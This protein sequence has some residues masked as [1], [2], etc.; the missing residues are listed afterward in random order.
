MTYCNHDARTGACMLINCDEC[1]NKVG[2]RATSCPECGAPVASG[3]E[4]DRRPPS[5][6]PPSVD[7]SSLQF[8]QSKADRNKLG[9]PVGLTLVCLAVGG[10]GVFAYKS[11]SGT[12]S[13]G[14]SSANRSGN[15]GAHPQGGRGSMEKDQFVAC[16][17]SNSDRLD[18]LAK[19]QSPNGNFFVSSSRG[20]S[21]TA[22]DGEISVSVRRSEERFIRSAVTAIQCISGLNQQEAARLLIDVDTESRRN[23]GFG[24]L[25][26]DSKKYSIYNFGNSLMLNVE[27]CKSSC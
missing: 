13:A 4:A 20:I 3:K 23:S 17:N 7:H 25:A 2:D 18:Q 26:F 14:P 24:G 22:D 10:A 16:W 9:F 8:R 1:G 27:A 15:S 11:M 21:V 6:Q 5:V 12:G 19:E